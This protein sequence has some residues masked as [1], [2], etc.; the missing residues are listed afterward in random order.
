MEKQNKWLFI[1]VT[2]GC[3]MY[4]SYYCVSLIVVW[5]VCVGIITCL[6]HF[7]CSLSVD[8]VESVGCFSTAFAVIPGHVGNWL[9]CMDLMKVFL[10]D[11][12]ALVGVFYEASFWFH[13]ICIVGRLYCHVHYISI[14]WCGGCIVV[15]FFSCFHW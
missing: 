10:W 13:M 6:V 5:C 1:S 15:G 11:K 4:A 12:E 3:L 7:M 8:I 2:C 9:F 14:I